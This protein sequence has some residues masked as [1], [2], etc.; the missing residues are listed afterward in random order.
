MER[1]DRLHAP[2]GRRL[3]GHRIQVADLKVAEIAAVVWHNAAAQDR[4]DASL[5][6]GSAASGLLASE[7]QQRRAEWADRNSRGI[8]GKNDCRQLEQ[9]GG[10]QSAG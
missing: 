4:R 1:R 2:T 3:R 9:D 10:I 6:L 5:S 7:C 8:P